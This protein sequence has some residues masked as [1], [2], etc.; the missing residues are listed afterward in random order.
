[1]QQQ[2]GHGCWLPGSDSTLQ[3]RVPM[4]ILHIKTC[5]LHSHLVLSSLWNR[6]ASGYAVRQLCSP[7]RLSLVI[8][9]HHLRLER[10]VE[11]TD[12]AD[13]VDSRIVSHLHTWV[14]LCNIY[15]YYAY[16]HTPKKEDDFKQSFA[17]PTSLLCRFEWLSAACRQWQAGH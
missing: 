1:M 16:Y 14:L 9:S 7:L 10:P 5:I 8:A 12:N 3:G 2:E 13:S 17:G 11:M 4:N 15:A 6:I